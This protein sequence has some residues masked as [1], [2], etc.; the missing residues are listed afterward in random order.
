MSHELENIVRSKSNKINI[1]FM[2]EASNDVTD[3]EKY[4]LGGSF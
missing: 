1:N 4:F 2:M 3:P